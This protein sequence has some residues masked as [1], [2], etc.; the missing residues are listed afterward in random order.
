[1]YGVLGD[2]GRGLAAGNEGLSILAS[3]SYPMTKDRLKSESTCSQ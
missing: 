2:E 3:D 1:M